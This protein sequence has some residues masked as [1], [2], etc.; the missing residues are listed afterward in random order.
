MINVIT[1]RQ[2]LN[3]A[4]PKLTRNSPIYVSPGIN[5]FPG[6]LLNTVVKIN[7]N[8]IIE[9]SN[10]S[11]LLSFSLFFKNFIKSIIKKLNIT[12]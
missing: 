5:P 7:D 8:I 3:I 11:N 6:K 12:I 2:E 10:I 1:K 4:A 9:I